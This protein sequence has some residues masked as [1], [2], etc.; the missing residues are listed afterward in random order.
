MRLPSRALKVL[1]VAALPLALAACSSG[2]GDSGKDTAASTKAKDPDAG[3][4]TG[5]QLKKA[6]APASSFPS[7]FALD[8][9]MS[10]DTGDSYQTQTTKSAAKPQCAN[11]GSTGWIGL[12][13][14]DGVSFAQNSHADSKIPAEL[15]QEI[16]VYRGSTSAEVMKG[17]TK[18]VAACPGYTDS[19]TNSKVKVTGVPTP[20]LGDQAYTITLTDPTWTNGTTLIAA[21][22]GTAVVSVLSTDGSDN[23]AASAKKLAAEV[24]T[25]VKGLK[26]QQG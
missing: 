12:T 7:S 4:P 1:A 5:T 9:S 17:L 16:D 10:R 15:D 21:R 24:V 8:A 25:S 6:L 23:G 19:D 26:T 18:V 3:L 22:V 20:G 11:L 14:I 2:S 13:G